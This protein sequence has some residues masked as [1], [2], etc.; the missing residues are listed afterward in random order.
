MGCVVMF[1]YL[2]SLYGYPTR[3]TFETSVFERA[4]Q[5]HRYQLLGSV[6]NVHPTLFHF[7]LDEGFCSAKVAPP[8]HQSRT[9]GRPG[10]VMTIHVFTMTKSAESMGD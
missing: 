3:E 4:S 9:G 8:L 6:I 7:H 10:S 1:T 2:F 5:V